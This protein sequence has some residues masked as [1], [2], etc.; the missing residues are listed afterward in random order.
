VVLGKP[1]PAFFEAAL[2]RLD[3]DAADAFMIGDDI[4]ADVGGAKAAGL[5]GILVKTGKYRSSD[6]EL[7]IKP[8]QVLDS[9]ADLP[10]L[11]D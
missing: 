4:K 9:L 3:V 6:L 11:F 10:R 1:A 7:G 8:D 2:K 5:N